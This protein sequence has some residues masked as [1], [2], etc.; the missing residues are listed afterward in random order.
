MIGIGPQFGRHREVN[1][2]FFYAK[3]KSSGQVGL[4]ITHHVPRVKKEK[5]CPCP[6][7]LTGPA[8]G[9][10]GALPLPPPEGPPPDPPADPP[11][12]SVAMDAGGNLLY[13]QEVMDALVEQLN[14]EDQLFEAAD[15]RDE[16]LQRDAQDL[17]QE[18]FEIRGEVQCI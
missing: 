11:T 9:P 6:P 7:D 14:L 5:T 2:Q 15:H 18:P 13:D 1:K 3:V 16:W 8:P 12:E 4:N 10:P 17:D